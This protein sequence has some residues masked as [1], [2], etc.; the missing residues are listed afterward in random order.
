MMKR[1]YRAVGAE[2]PSLSLLSDYTM[3]SLYSPEFHALVPY[4]W[5]KP[6]FA[7]N[8][9]LTSFGEKLRMSIAKQMGSRSYQNLRAPSLN[10]TFEFV[11]APYN[12]P[13]W[14]DDRTSFLQCL[15]RS[16]KINFAHDKSNFDGDV[17]VEDH[18]KNLV[19]WKLKH[20]EGRGVLIQS[21]YLESLFDEEFVNMFGEGKTILPKLGIKVLP[22]PKV[23]AFLNS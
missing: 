9:R 5:A 4:I 19:A 17:F 8:M 2:P 18:P 6:R 1:V 12:S 10:F 3:K 13:T 22:L 7:S 16:P 15:F 20:P 14:V 23:F 21:R 11:T